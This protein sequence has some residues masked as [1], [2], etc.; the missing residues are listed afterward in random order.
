MRNKI[1]YSICFGFFA[2]VFLA[3]LYNFTSAY[4]YCVFLLG[5]VFLILFFFKKSSLFV[6]V[7]LFAF[8]VLLGVLRLNNF[9]L[10]KGDIL[11]IQ[12]AGESVSVTGIIE[13]SDIREKNQKLIVEVQ[14]L[15][16]EVL[17][18]PTKI[19]V[20]TDPYSAYAYGDRIDLSGI[21]QRPQNFIDEETGR[22]F[23]YISYLRKDKIFYEIRNGEIQVVSSGDGNKIIAFL[24]KTKNLFI[25]KS[26]KY[27]NNTE[28]NLLSGL[29]LGAKSGIPENLKENFIRTGTIHIVALS[30]YNIM[31][32]S[33]AV[34]ATL[35]FLGF[36]AS[37]IVGLLAIIVFIFMTGLQSTAIRAGIMAMVAVTGKLLGRFYDAG[38]TLVLAAFIMIIW[39]PMTFV[40][41]ISFQLS[42]L[43]TAGIIYLMPIL[44]EKFYFLKKFGSPAGGLREIVS[45]T[46]SAYIIV[47]PLILYDMGRISLV[48]LPA[49]I[50]ILPLVP[51]TMLFGF[52]TGAVGFIS[53]T[54]S[55]PFS[56]LTHILLSW[57]IG[58]VNF[59][60]SFKFSSIIIPPMPFVVCVLLYIPIIY[61]VWRHKRKENMA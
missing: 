3:S 41:D 34:V 31:I 60:G 9:V 23:D 54:F 57:E 55:F 43:A 5:L 45:G 19:L 27:L 12:S 24:L 25:E 56:F 32:V 2:G 58:V 33:L 40:F 36:Y 59:F 53:S 42:F 37:T 4:L 35:S 28:G 49:N 61:F 21:L 47:L 1:F 44:D 14:N 15:N 11:L 26:T 7:A 16:N 52:I 46:L 20:T 22:T 17:V 10:D 30:G 8:S 29:I 48:A 39:N 13:E 18:K 6:L 50:L 51:F 38:K